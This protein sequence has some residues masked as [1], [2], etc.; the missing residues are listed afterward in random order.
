MAILRGHVLGVLL[1][2]YICYLHF[3]G[4]FL[5]TRGFL[6]SRLAL[7]NTAPSLATTTL[8]PTHNRALVIIIDALRY[9]FVTP[10]P[11]SPH[12]G[13]HHSILTVPSEITAEYPQNSFLFHSYSDP[14]TT[15][16]QRLKAI[17]TGSLPTF[18]DQGNNFHSSSIEEDSIIHQIASSPRFPNRAFMG[19]DTWLSIYPSSFSPNLTHPFDSFN[20]EDLHSVDEGVTRSLLPLLRNQFP[21]GS[22]AEDQPFQFLVAHFLGVDH[23]GHRLGPDHPAMATK[24]R[25]MDNLLREVV[26]LLQDDTLLVVLGDH[27][28]DPK[29]DHGGDSVLEVSTMTWL[30]SPGAALHTLPSPLPS[31]LTPYTTYPGSPAPARSVQ[32]IDLLPSLSLLLGLPIPFNNLGCVIPELFW[33]PG[34]LESALRLNAAQ[35]WEYFLAYRA[36]GAG[37][38][39]DEAWDGLEREWVTAKSVGRA[40][41]GTGAGDPARILAQHAFVRSALE[42]CRSLWAQFDVLMIGLGLGVLALSVG[43]LGALYRTLT[44]RLAWDELVRRALSWAGVGATGGALAGWAVKRFVSVQMVEKVLL[45]DWMLFGTSFGSAVLLLLSLLL[46]YTPLL[47]PKLSFPALLAFGIITLHAV[48]FSSN[49]FILWEDHVVPFFLLTLLLPTLLSAPSAP[50]RTLQYRLLGFSLLLAGCIRLMSISTVCREEQHPNCHVTFYAS[51]T[52]PVSPSVILLLSLPAAFLLPRAILFLLSQSKS[53]RGPAPLFLSYYLRPALLASALYWLIEHLESW[54]GLNPDRV[55]ALKAFRML[56]AR[57]SL[58][59]T[60]FAGYAG[61]AVAPPCVELQLF[62][63]PP[64]SPRQ[65]KQLIVLGYSNAYGALYLLFLLVFFAL[66]FAATQLTGQVVLVLWLLALLSLLEQTD[67]GR[68]AARLSSLS[69]ATGPKI[70]EIATLALLGQLLFFTT[71]H[72][73]VMST[74][75]WKSAFIGFPAVTYPFSP[76]LVGLNFAGPVFLSALA[77][78]LLAMWQVSPVITTSQPEKVKNTSADTNANTSAGKVHVLPDTLKSCI[79]FSLTNSLLALSSAASAAWLRRHLMV[80]K[81]FAPRFMLGGVMLLVVDLGLVLAVGVG[82][83]A[84]C[85]KVKRMFGTET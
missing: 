20:V 75:Q 55:P 60:L 26:D 23:V 42:T 30:Y 45:S 37:G 71:G 7:S 5:F 65:G 38:E 19:D 41:A 25:Q 29:G 76:L 57:I 66:L 18:I 74:I 11:P 2:L 63:P 28:M 68:D 62:E 4:L 80:W 33:R 73:A 58:S 82:S 22:K 10:Y 85:H 67:A 50:T 12:S 34:A 17:T 46:P 59:A 72:Q 51:S 78:P 64:S 54:R 56:F 39:L 53:D 44:H 6:L 35:I 70:T 3:T 43:V 1:L 84:T 9:D 15:T 83:A 36:S 32:Q 14:P 40:N 8:T 13:Y 81:V 77:V 31:E 24:L 79:G 16:L 21:P 48:S 61:W 49:S 69:P 27:G 52:T 47:L